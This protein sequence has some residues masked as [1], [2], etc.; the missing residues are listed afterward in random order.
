MLNEASDGNV[1]EVGDEP[2]DPRRGWRIGAPPFG[3]EV[4]G[5]YAGRLGVLFHLKEGGKEGVG[6]QDSSMWEGNPRFTH[7]AKRLGLFN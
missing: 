5:N 7:P 1:T 3:L 4:F 6:T 2:S